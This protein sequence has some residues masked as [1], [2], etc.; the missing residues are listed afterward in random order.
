MS[1]SDAG[2]PALFSREAGPSSTPR[3][4]L[5][6]VFLAFQLLGLIGSVALV[7]T[8][9]LSTRATRNATWQNFFTSW[10]VSTV[11]YSLLLFAGQARRAQPAFGVC[12]AQAGLIYGIPSLTAATT[13]GLI[14][15]A[16]AT[17]RPYN[18]TPLTSSR[19]DLVQGADALAAESPE[20]AALDGRVLAKIL[21]LPYCMLFGMVVA[22][23]VTGVRNPGSVAIIGS[24]MYCHIGSSSTLGK[25]SAALVA[26]TLI[27]TLT[28]EILICIALRKNWATFA[29]MHNAMSIILRVVVFTL[30]GILAISLSAL[31]VFSSN[32]GPGVNIALA[33]M[34]VIAV[35]VFATQKD[36][37]AVWM[38]W[39]PASAARTGTG[40]T[41]ADADT[42]FAESSRSSASVAS[43][44]V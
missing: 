37:L 41:L 10:I 38:F 23:W 31:F 40:K 1:F 3:T 27:P 33:A 20:R 34:P 39:R 15:Q 29:R 13:F 8:T 42:S 26:L 2:V 28:F 44:P 6:D 32:H 18:T 17:A 16:S 36:I 43:A 24:G 11:S 5:I 9:T 4:A 7:L 35:L 12:L 22:S 25:V 21:V 30:I 14:A 19:A